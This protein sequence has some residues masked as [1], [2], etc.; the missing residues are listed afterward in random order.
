MISSI[1]PILALSAIEWTCAPHIGLTTIEFSDP[2][3]ITLK[4]GIFAGVATPNGTEK[5]LG[6]PYAQPPLG[7]LRFK[8]PLFPKAS[9]EVRDA[10]QFGN[11][12]PQPLSNSLGAAIGE[13][14][15][16][17]NVRPP[18]CYFDGCNMYS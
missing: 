5:W 14:C 4:T 16:V 12:C 3:Q 17:L 18:T 2:L 10:S 1:L 6:I 7:T 11:A 8:A 9:R 15:L 13:D